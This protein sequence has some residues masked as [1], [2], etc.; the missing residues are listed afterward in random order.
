MA[1]GAVSNASAFA[2]VAAGISLL[3]LLWSLVA[4]I[5]TR[6]RLSR[7]ERR[8]LDEARELANREQHRR[9]LNDGI[10]YLLARDDQSRAIGLINLEQLKHATWATDQDK[11]K[12]AAVIGSVVEDS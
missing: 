4:F 6:S 1:V 7:F 2:G 9:E 8:S 3:T 11:V 5:L 12:V 10:G